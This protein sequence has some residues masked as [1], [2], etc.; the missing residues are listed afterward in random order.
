V[1]AREDDAPPSA[2]PAEPLAK[3]APPRDLEGVFEQMRTRVGAHEGHA[4]AAQLE[5]GL[6]HLDD[7]RIADAVADLQAAA[8]A[9]MLRFTAASALGRLYASQRD[10]DAAVEWLERA[11]QAPAPSEGDSLAVLYEL[12][13]VL[14]RLGEPARAL[15]VLL[16]IDAD[17][18]AYRDVPARI[19]QL[20]RAQAGS[21]RS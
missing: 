9:P 7:G 14:E 12:A 4:P 18:G 20:T 6:R 5:R 11:A 17:F 2:P 3:A 13:D 10:L 15:A 1:A 16:E 8:R 19:E 21:R